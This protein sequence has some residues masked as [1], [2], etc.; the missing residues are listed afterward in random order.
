MASDIARPATVEQSLP[1][2]TTQPPKSPP[3]HTFPRIN[4]NHHLPTAPSSTPPF[5]KPHTTPRAK[6]N[7]T[8]TLD[9]TLVVYVAMAA[10]QSNISDLFWTAGWSRVQVYV[11]RD[12]CTQKKLGVAFVTFADAATATCA[13][14]WLERRPRELCGRRLRCEVATRGPSTPDQMARKRRLRVYALQGWIDFD[15][16]DSDT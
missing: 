8:S 13:K 12:Y 4:L 2:G 6:K 11:P 10:S 3:Q 15:K 5:A 16:P 9:A 14:E 1:E 7:L